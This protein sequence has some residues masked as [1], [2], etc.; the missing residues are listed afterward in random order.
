MSGQKELKTI[1]SEV[2]TMARKKASE[3][4]EERKKGKRKSE[5]RKGGR[6]KKDDGVAV[7][8]LSVL[9]LHN[10]A[11]LTVLHSFAPFTA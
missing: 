2:E 11:Q 5:G 6:Q 3:A 10:N 4:K 7:S 9:A 8:P 1:L